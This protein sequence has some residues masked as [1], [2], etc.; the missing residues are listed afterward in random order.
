MKQRVPFEI[1]R[2]PQ[3]AF[4][5][6][7]GVCRRQFGRDRIRDVS[8]SKLLNRVPTQ[9]GCRE[10]TRVKDTGVFRLRARGEQ[11]CSGRCRSRKWLGQSIRGAARG[12]ARGSASAAT[13]PPDDQVQGRLR[14]AAPT[15]LGSRPAP[16]GATVAGIT[17]DRQCRSFL[18]H[19]GLAQAGEISG[20]GQSAVLRYPPIFGGPEASYA[21]KAIV[22]EQPPGFG[23]F[24]A[25]AVELSR[26]SGAACRCARLT[27]GTI[28]RPGLS[29]RIWS[30]MAGRSRG[31]A[32]CRR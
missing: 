23:K 14:R 9:P 16:R 20:F 24:R 7:V 1:C 6:Q 28:H 25:G 29:R 10:R 32:S 19:L 15:P 4:F 21:R 13:Q 22:A 5:H 8:I 3:R 12:L 2:R 30:L 27:A 17:A 18:R 11:R 31:A 26:R